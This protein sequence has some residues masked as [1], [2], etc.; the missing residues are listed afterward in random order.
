[1]VSSRSDLP[2]VVDPDT[3]VRLFADDALVYRV[4]NTIQDRVILQQDFARLE[5]WAKAWGMV[6]NASKCYVM[7]IHRRNSTKSSERQ[8]IIFGL[9][10]FFQN[11][12][13]LLFTLGIIM[14]ST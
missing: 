14:I 3:S 5:G 2:S 6:F 9:L 13:G 12:I 10:T 4:I 11:K 8:K 7:H 1:M